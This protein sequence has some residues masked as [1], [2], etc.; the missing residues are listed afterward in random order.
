MAHAVD[1]PEVVRK[2]PRIGIGTIIEFRVSGREGMK[3]FAMK[4]DYH[5]P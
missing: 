4:L 3:R 1:V 5:F 2:I